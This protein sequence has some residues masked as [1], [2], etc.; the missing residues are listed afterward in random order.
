MVARRHHLCRII[1][2]G[3]IFLRLFLQAH[4]VQCS[5]GLV[6]CFQKYKDVLLEFYVSF[7]LYKKFAHEY[8]NELVFD[9]YSLL[10]ISSNNSEI[11]VLKSFLFI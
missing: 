11:P 3:L 6:A 2:M 9:K 8:N 10:F 1:K 5:A 4:Y 7:F